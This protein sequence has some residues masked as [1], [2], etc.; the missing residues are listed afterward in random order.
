MA[1]KAGNASVLGGASSGEYISVAG[2]RVDGRR[3]EEVRRIRTRFGLFSRVDGSSYYEQGNTKVVAVVYGPREL[4][5]AAAGSASSGSASVGTGSGNAA[6]N[7]QPRATVNC[8]FTQAAFATSERKP[9]RSGD[10][11]K[12]ELSLAVKQIFEACIQTQLYPRSQ[13]DIFVQVLHADGGEL[14][15]SIN[16]ITLALIDAG[17]AINDFDGWSDEL[18][19]DASLADLNYAEEVARAPQMV[20]ALNPRT[21]KLNLLQMECKLPLELFESL[22]EVATEGC[23]QI[24]DLLQNAVRENTWKRLRSRGTAAASAARP[25]GAQTMDRRVASASPRVLTPPASDAQENQEPVHAAM[26]A[27][28]AVVAPGPPAKVEATQHSS[29]SDPSHRKHRRALNNIDGNR[30]PPTLNRS[31]P[32][33]KRPLSAQPTR[34]PKGPVQAALPGS[35]HSH[36]A[37][38]IDAQMP[39]SGDTK[40][41]PRAPLTGLKRLATSTA[42][43]ARSPP[44]AS[45]LSEAKESENLAWMDMMLALLEKRYGPRSTLPVCV[46]DLEAADMFQLRRTKKHKPASDAAVQP[47]TAPAQS[48]T[49]NSLSK[50]RTSLGPNRIRP[51]SGPPDTALSTTSGASAA[52]LK[53][54]IASEASVLRPANTPG[55]PARTDQEHEEKVREEKRQRLLLRHA[56]QIQASSVSSSTSCGC[57]TGCLKMY[58]MCFSSRGY[59]HAG[60]ACDACKNARNNKAERV[61]AIQN[62]LA[63]DPRAF[64]YASLPQDASTTGF[65]HLLPRNGVGCTAHCRCVDCSN[66]SESS[67]AHQHRH[68]QKGSATSLGKRAHAGASVSGSAGATPFHPV[69]V[70][71]TKQPKRNFVLK[72]LRLNL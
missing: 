40:A 20:I 59:C 67:A 1:G 52:S 30:L 53:Q 60:C 18:H 17:I 10:R 2:L 55:I 70:T 41:A 16:A 72:T 45:P 31:P 32:P 68:L 23:N 6:S 15:A 35:S 5:M 34:G 38:P 57:K 69:Q 49:S 4:K 37:R 56:L 48:D 7:T 13:I 44:D 12:L 42:N 29:A 61:E 65:L 25:R 24:Y 46:S 47:P 33:P 71:V 9:Q 26:D 58:C 51:S 11:K 28:C 62:Y 63:N 21:Q 64:S 54:R 27:Q 43:G 8:E 50:P 66:H 14:A 36:V 22:M 3:S 19:L 39:R